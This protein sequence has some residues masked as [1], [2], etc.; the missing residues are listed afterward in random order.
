MLQLN[1]YLREKLV[2]FLSL[3]AMTLNFYQHYETDEIIQC[4]SNV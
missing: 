3:S 4:F 2:K 1:F